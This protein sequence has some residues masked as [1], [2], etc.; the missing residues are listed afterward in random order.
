MDSKSLEGRLS[1]FLRVTGDE[2]MSQYER[3][4]E[5]IDRSAVRLCEAAGPPGTAF[6][7]KDRV[8]NS[9]RFFFSNPLSSFEPVSPANRRMATAFSSAKRSKSTPSSKGKKEVTYDFDYVFTEKDPTESLLGHLIDSFSQ[10]LCLVSV[11]KSNVLNDVLPGI[12]AKAYREGWRVKL[13]VSTVSGQKLV[14]FLGTE[15]PEFSSF[16][17]AMDALCSSEG[18]S[19]RRTGESVAVVTMRLELDQESRVVQVVDVPVVNKPTDLLF[20]VIANSDS[21][22]DASAIDSDKLL[23]LVK[24]SLN[25]SAVV[26]VLGNVCPTGPHYASASSLLKLME[27]LM[28][29]KHRCETLQAKILSDQ[30]RQ[31]K[32]TLQMAHDEIE[33][34]RRLNHEAQGRYEEQTRA[35]EHD[36]GQM[37][38]QLAEVKQEKGRNS[39][40]FYQEA[41]MLKE[42]EVSELRVRLHSQHS[43]VPSAEFVQKQLAAK[44]NQIQYLEGLLGAQRAAYEQSQQALRPATPRPLSVTTVDGA[45]IEGDKSAH[46]L[47][48]DMLKSSWSYTHS[49]VTQMNQSSMQEQ[50]ISQSKA[51]RLKARATWSQVELS[52]YKQAYLEIASQLEIVAREKYAQ[53]NELEAL[54]DLLSRRQVDVKAA[55]RTVKDNARNVITEK[56]NLLKM[57]TKENVQLRS[58]VSD[59]TRLTEQIAELQAQVEN[60]QFTAARHK[61]ESSAAAADI[62]RLEEQV[63]HLRELRKPLRH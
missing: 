44:D 4:I 38:I 19:K 42:A 46:L 29:R 14:N 52:S 10:S 26:K 45:I 35:L 59:T 33:A 54:R 11:G 34:Q 48:V 17:A 31:L 37:R 15:D 36:L 22:K 40:A 43:E 61:E 1:V 18:L 23:K 57:T 56:K 53:D 62:K 20:R 39:E 16:E 9:P 55:I 6:M 12:L 60:W 41:L 50:L 58:Q 47:L 13:Q 7:K 3:C 21:P 5:V 51:S 63:T 32:R 2:A 30:V 8:E 28:Q 25:A 49:L 24:K 27:H